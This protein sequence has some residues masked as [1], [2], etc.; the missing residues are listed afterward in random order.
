MYE[1]YKVIFEISMTVC[2]P[3][4]GKIT[5]ASNAVSVLAAR[6]GTAVK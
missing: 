1:I 2:I 5:A 4:N 3:G 6:V